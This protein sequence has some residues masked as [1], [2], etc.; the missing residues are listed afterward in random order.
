MP[1]VTRPA[2][3]PTVKPSAKRNVS[4]ET[5]AERLGAAGYTT[6]HIG[7]WHLSHIGEN[8]T[9]GKSKQAHYPEHQGFDFNI[10]GNSAGGPRSYFAPYRNDMLP[11]GE[12]GEYL[13]ER[14]ADE[15]IAFIKQNKGKPF[16]LNYWLYSVHYPMQARKELIDKYEKRKGPGLPNPTYAAMIEGMDAELGRLFDALDE[17]GLAENTLVIFKSD[18]GGEAGD[19]SPLRGVK[20]YLYEGYSP[21]RQTVSR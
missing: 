19:N 10:G 2:S 4:Y 5:I 11:D 20:G 13:P 18:N 7:K 3:C 1:P 12:E 9:S 6:A 15:A 8:D 16:Y 21:A 14:L 17:A